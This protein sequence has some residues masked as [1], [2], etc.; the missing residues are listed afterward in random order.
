MSQAHER[1]TAL[2]NALRQA[3]PELKSVAAH[4]EPLG[5]HEALSEAVEMNSHRIQDVIT[6]LPQ[7]VKGLSDC[8]DISV[9][10]GQG[11]LGL[12]PLHGGPRY[13]HRRGARAHGAN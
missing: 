10:R 5:D 4:I 6:G 8:H 11:N 3:V 9:L 2:E 12:L 1:V 13:A 7:E